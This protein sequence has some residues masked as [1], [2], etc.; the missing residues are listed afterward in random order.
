MK[1]NFEK[2]DRLA[3]IIYD[4]CLSIDSYHFNGAYK[5]KTSKNEKLNRLYQSLIDIHAL[6]LSTEEKYKLK[7]EKFAEA[8]GY[9]D[10]LKKGE[11]FLKLT[12]DE[13]K[14]LE[15]L[16]KA[17]WQTSPIRITLNGSNPEESLKNFIDKH[18][19]K[20]PCKKVMFETILR[21]EPTEVEIEKEFWENCT[22]VTDID[23]FCNIYREH[24]GKRL[25]EVDETFY[26]MDTILFDKNS[27]LHEYF[28]DLRICGFISY[29][30]IFIECRLMHIAK[31]V[32]L[33]SKSIVNVFK[34]MRAST[35][36][37]ITSNSAIDGLLNTICKGIS[38][39]Q[40]DEK[41]HKCS[42]NIVKGINLES[43]FQIFFRSL[44][45]INYE[46]ADNEV[47]KANR[48]IDLKLEDSNKLP[49]RIIVEF[50]GWWNKDKYS[51]IEQCL[52]YVTDFEENA[53]VFMVNHLEKTIDKKYKEK[54]V[55]NSYSYKKDSWTE[56]KYKETGYTYFKSE[57][58]DNDK[59][60]TIYHFIVSPKIYCK[61]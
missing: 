55:M 22:S 38:I 9:K 5:L 57:H 12:F 1:I 19:S 56:V 10:D 45:S 29:S 17:Y 41:K 40:Q 61:N 4:S 36:Q 8:Y 46:C 34:K 47:E 2:S 13:E 58:L 20:E 23:S 32:N 11:D 35:H 31:S 18:Y 39:L 26:D 24:L 27:L 16:T 60:K 21:Q 48:R 14:V 44:L 50:K 42:E 30:E 3:E 51:V 43:P 37:T 59:T 54:V 49:H 7:V 52:G 28:Q 33:I 53:I 25:M 15:R 6:N